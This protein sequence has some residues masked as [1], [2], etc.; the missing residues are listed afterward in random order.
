MA[1]SIDG[2]KVKELREARLLERP[3][4][5]ELAGIKYTTMYRIEANGHTPRLAT[6]RKLAKALKVKPAEILMREGDT[7][8]V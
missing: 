1:V 2:G 5:A 7:A 4:L 6:V 3:E 8:G